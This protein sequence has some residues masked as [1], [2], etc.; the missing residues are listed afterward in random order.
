MQRVNTRVARSVGNAMKTAGFVLGF[1]L[2]L[3]ACA[4]D[5]PPPETTATQ[6]RAASA[7]VPPSAEVV[8]ELRSDAEVDELLHAIKNG[9]GAQP[10]P[11]GITR[12]VANAFPAAADLPPLP[13]RPVGT[14]MGYLLLDLDNAEVLAEL[15]PDVPLIPASTVKV[16]TAIVALDLLGPEHR[17]RTDLL[18]DGTVQ[19]G[20]L[21]GDLILRG[22]G[23]PVLD[24]ADLLELSVKLETSGIQAV[25]GRFLID[26][27]ALPR[28]SEIEPSQ[29]PEA[30]YNPSV[31]ALSLARNRVRLAWRGGGRVD[32][33]TLPPLEEA[34]FEPASPSRLPP[35]GIGLKEAGEASVVWRVADR[36]RL[37]QERWLP[38]K[39]PGLHA[40]SVFHQFAEAQGIAL[41]LPQRGA[42]PR[43][44][45]ILASHESPP[46]RPILREMLLHSN[47]M[48]AELIGLTAASRLGDVSGGLA[49]AGGLLVDHLA[50][51]MPTVDWR[52][53]VLT[54]HS[55]LDGSARLT[56]HQLAAIL[57]HGWR[58]EALPA[59]LPAAGWSGTLARRFDEDEAFRVWAKTGTVNYGLAL[60]GYLFPETGRPAVFVAM[61]SDLD[62][63]DAYDALPTPTSSSE[64]AAGTWNAQARF[65]QDGLVE[66]WLGELP[67]S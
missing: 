64:A 37:R 63:R 2:L 38:V 33:S 50:A 52:G 19:G 51:T 17:F 16:A 60:A 67:T 9:D 21:S 41:P 15:N 18:I 34:A 39:D 58:N 66:G 59:L 42:A 26:D 56:P 35:G 54:N 8:G 48:M 7:A 29:P 20:R 28:F 25:D 11:A 10:S 6:Q 30:A 45:R 36:G 55:G 23:D 1:G 49:T 22:G 27:F 44:A 24:V 5:P 62:A 57:L 3:A 46:L 12:E 40:G 53:A 65:L 31:G 43:R 4:S 47:N 13:P 32:A 14:T 61:V